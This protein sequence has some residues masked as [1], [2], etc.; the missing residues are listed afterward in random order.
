[1]GNCC[2]KDAVVVDLP[3][4][5]LPPP[6]RPK[7]NSIYMP[8][9]SDYYHENSMKSNASSTRHRVS[10]EQAFLNSILQSIADQVV[11][12]T[13]IDVASNQHD[14]L[15]RAQLYEVR[16]PEV[17]VDDSSVP[18][19]A[20]LNNGLYRHSVENPELVLSGM[21]G[22]SDTN[23]SMIEEQAIFSEECDLLLA[24]DDQLVIDFS[25]K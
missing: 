8:T 6:E 12:I 18:R 20:L 21:G 1:M 22:V 19:T 7:S 25:L 15:E 14:Y 13:S 9:S 24:Q 10:A 2:D 3:S 23:L 5:P 16:L 4:A 17:F 11:D